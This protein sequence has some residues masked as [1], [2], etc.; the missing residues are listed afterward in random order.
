MIIVLFSVWKPALS[1]VQQKSVT[2]A[3]LF[4]FL[5]VTWWNRGIEG[6]PVKFSENIKLQGSSL[7]VLQR[8]LMRL[9]EERTKS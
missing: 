7:F 1:W 2:R 6:T 9:E 5:P 4:E 3:I 8:D